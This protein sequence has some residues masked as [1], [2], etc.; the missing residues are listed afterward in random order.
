MSAPFIMT[1][2]PQARLRVELGNDERAAT[3]EAKRSNGQAWRAHGCVY[4]RA[5]VEDGRGRGGCGQVGGTQLLNDGF[6][7]VVADGRSNEVPVPCARA[8]AQTQALGR[9]TMVTGV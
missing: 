8:Q 4:I 9:K 7:L 6:A 2:P 1:S 3:A 5:S